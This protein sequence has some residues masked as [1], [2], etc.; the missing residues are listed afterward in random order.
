MIQMCKSL[1][2]VEGVTCNAF[3]GLPRYTGVRGH[4]FSV[5]AERSG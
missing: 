4:G 3:V 5:H 2:G 1:H